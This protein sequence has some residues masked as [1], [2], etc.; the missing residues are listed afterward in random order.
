MKIIL[1]LSLWIYTL[2]TFG[3]RVRDFAYLFP[4][5]LVQWEYKDFIKYNIKKVSAFGSYEEGSILFYEKEFDKKLNRIFGMDSYQG[6]N[7]GCSFKT[8]TFE[9]FYDKNG[10]IIKEIIDS[11]ESIA[12]I[13]YTYS[14]YTIKKTTK[15]F[16]KYDSSTTVSINY[17]AKKINY[18][19]KYS[20]KVNKQNNSIIWIFYDNRGLIKKKKYH[21]YDEK[22]RIKKELDSV[23]INST[24]EFYL[25]QYT[26]FEYIDTGYVRKDYNYDSNT[27][28][29]SFYNISDTKIQEYQQ[30]KSFNDIFYIYKNN[31]LVSSIL[32]DVRTDFYY[33][34]NN[35]IVEERIFEKD[36]L[37]GTVK[38]LY[39][40][41]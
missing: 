26:E 9:N 8:W 23:R 12:Q 2:F 4:Q 5:D 16:R 29:T 31:M 37:E 40:Y 18:N 1:I 20:K 25:K 17:I 22:S 35:L 3:Q 33:N 32:R 41:Y 19:S 11:Y 13:F 28:S 36:K 34:S 21:L 10:N 27:Q 15:E 7:M 24:K 39:E 6:D 30:N 38:Y 14:D